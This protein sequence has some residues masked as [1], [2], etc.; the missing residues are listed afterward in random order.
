MSTPPATATSPKSAKSAKSPAKSLSKSPTQQATVN[1]ENTGVL[2]PGHWQ[3]LAEE[4]NGN[5]D[6]DAHSLSDQSLTSSTE[7]VTASI[8]EYRKLHGRTYHHEIGNAQY[9]AA[10]DERQS[11]LLDMNHHCLTLGIKGK[12]HLAPIDTSRISKALDIGTGTGI[13]A[14][15]FADEHPNIEVI[16]TDVSPIQPSWVPPNVQFEIEDCTREWTFTPDSVDYIHIR[17]LV[18]AIP[19]WYGFF[20][21]AYKTCKPG[22]WVESHEPSGIITSD[23]DTVKENSALDQWGKIFIEG[24]KKLGNSF[25]VYEHELQRKAMEAAG[26]VDIQQFEYKSPIGGWPK[27]PEMK[28]LGQYGKLAFLADPEG[29]VLFVA[30]TIGWSESEIHVFLA[31]ARREVNSG[32][33]HPYFK[34]RVIWGRKPEE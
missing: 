7:S 11:E 19:D 28:E 22:G 30:N 25:E 34:Q 21:E 26:F 14:I 23:D 9:W 2:E 12:L 29:F 17:W 13:W 18:G 32:K 20:T 16:G 6:D 3:Q 15:D 10:N 24:G 5:Y 4:E 27:D 1:V 33:H 31:Q 8:F